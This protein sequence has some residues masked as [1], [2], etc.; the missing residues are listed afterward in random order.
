MS[1]CSVL[2]FRLMQLIS[3]ANSSFSGLRDSFVT[4][5]KLEVSCN[6][7]FTSPL[8][9]KTYSAFTNRS[10][11]TFFFPVV[12]KPFSA[13][14]SR[15]CSTVRGDKLSCSS[16]SL[17]YRSLAD[18]AAILTTTWGNLLTVRRFNSV[19]PQRKY[20]LTSGSKDQIYVRKL[21]KTQLSS[22]HNV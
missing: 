15:S 19:D 12:G 1:I 14:L 4:S 10:S 21:D 9:G 17:P 16:V 13:S 7:D 5:V 20:R 6:S 18:L 2:A 11:K 22:Q 3:W 8:V